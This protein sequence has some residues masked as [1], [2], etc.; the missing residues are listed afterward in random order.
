M[1]SQNDDRLSLRVAG[2]AHNDWLD[3]E[4]DSDLL[5]PAD[6]WSVSVGLSSGTLPAEVVEGA[7]AELYAGNDL[8]MTGRI[9]EI[10]Q[11]VTPKQ[12]TITLSGRDLA[13]WLVDCSA[14]VFT[15]RDMSLTEVIAQV[16]KPFGI[17][18]IDIRAESSTAPKKFSIEP[19]ESAWGALTKTAEVSGLWPWMAPNG[20][21]IV[22]GPDYTTPAVDTLVMK[23]EGPNNNLMA[24]SARRSINERFSETT[25]LAQGHGYGKENG[26]H[27][28]RSTATDTS[29]TFYRPR[30]EVCGDSDDD[31]EVQFRAKKL[32]ADARL[33]AFSMTATVKGLRTAS[34]V[35]WEP[36]QRVHVKSDPHNIDG[37]YFLMHRRFRGG[38]NTPR[39][40]LLTLVEDGVWLPDAYPKKK[41]K[42]KRKGK[43]GL[44]E[45]WESINNG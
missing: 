17:T 29:M 37:I 7:R 9:D 35:L 32:Q 40:T 42:R 22:G 38:R 16:I 34:G 21:L 11:N 39:V 36:G 8:I 24:L 28:R 10:D 33:N 4:V 26:K 43:A 5:T 25:V 23:R 12:H 30:I 41:H 31:A 3:F 20:T 1:P 14:P 2:V 44:W 19:G 27:D 15:A 45:N 13:G 18:K 6:A